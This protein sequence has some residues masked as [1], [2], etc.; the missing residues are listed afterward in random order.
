[1]ETTA[2]APLPPL[3]IPLPTSALAP[4]D[5]GRIAKQL[6]TEPQVT[7]VSQGSWPE[8]KGVRRGGRAY[9][10]V[11]TLR[12]ETAARLVDRLRGWTA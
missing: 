6:A 11:P 4:C 12:D 5:A 1:M 2:L 9:V 3:P 7:L 8:M 10:D